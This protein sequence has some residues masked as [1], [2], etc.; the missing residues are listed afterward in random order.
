MKRSIQIESRPN[1][2]SYWLKKNY[3]AYLI[4]LFP[5]Y[6]FIL[7]VLLQ[8]M[9]QSEFEAI[10]CHMLKARQNAFT[11]QVIHGSRK[12]GAKKNYE[13]PLRHTDSQLSPNTY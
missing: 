13:F 10:T 1:L 8:D 5:C 12:S 11:E 7:M 3:H 4:N 6:K 2:L 9:S